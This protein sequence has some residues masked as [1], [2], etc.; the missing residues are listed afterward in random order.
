MEEIKI[1][2][3]IE[4]KDEYDVAVC[5]GGVA[6]IS[7]ALA[8]ARL[9]AKVL[10]FDREFL[11][12]GLATLG[13]I[14]IYLPISDGNNHQI[15]FGIAEELLKLSVKNGTVAVKDF[16]GKWEKRELPDNLNG[17]YEVQYDPN[18][19]AI[20]TEKLLLENGV[21]ILYGTSINDVITEN[22]KITHLILSGR[23]DTFAVKVK[24]VVDASGDAAVSLLAGEK[25]KTTKNGN[26]IASWYYEQSGENLKLNMLGF[27]DVVSDS[28]SEED[29]IA[30]ANEKI[31]KRY[32]G[33]ES[34][35]LTEFSIEAHGNILNDFLKK[36]KV[37][38]DHAVTAVASIP[39]L[40]M[41][42]RING[43]YEQQATEIN[44]EYEDSVGMFV[45]WRNKG[46]IYELPFGCLHG[47][48]IKNLTVAGRCISSGEEMWDVTR[49]IP[50][51]AVS[52]QAA[53]TAAALSDDVT[54]ISIE[55][56][57]KVL[58]ESGVKLHIKD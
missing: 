50:V 52:G 51:C 35:E 21:K 4:I 56:L 13:L 58:K 49:A 38:A 5:G 41:T 7:A 22:G 39:Q 9:G 42:R 15:S 23:S 10:L 54:K 24:S 55:K 3:S 57:Q 16:K 30:R 11:L 33:L 17:R 37:S 34:D 2:K 46:V 25:T 14:A 29:I 40:R 12:G 20:N 8:A 27:S 19:F 28:D 43:K 31:S 6:G 36:G 48:K 45:D 32:V 26:K 18:I 44:T 1:Q 47:E 53:G